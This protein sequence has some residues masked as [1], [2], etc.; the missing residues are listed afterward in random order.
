MRLDPLL[1]REFARQF[2]R[3]THYQWNKL[4]SWEKAEEAMILVSEEMEIPWPE[5]KTRSKLKK[6]RERTEDYFSFVIKTTEA[7][8]EHKDPI[9]H[10]VNELII[11]ESFRWLNNQRNKPLTKPIEDTILGYLKHYCFNT[12]E[13]ES[14]DQEIWVNWVC[15][16]NIPEDT[17]RKRNEKGD[18]TNIQFIDGKPKKNDQPLKL[19]IDKKIIDREK[20]KKIDC[21]F[22][23]KTAQ[24]LANLIRINIGIN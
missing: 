4:F 22:N 14:F 3:S 19:R 24:E 1:Q 21:Y 10:C 2:E 16:G 11:T 6:Q 8:A 12:I 17:W 18:W 23:I 20:K 13:I 9:I 5:T 15:E 7:N